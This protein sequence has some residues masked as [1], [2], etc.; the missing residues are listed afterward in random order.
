MKRLSRMFFAA[1]LSSFLLTVYAEHA[2]T[3]ASPIRVFV[4]K[5][6]YTMDKGWPEA[7]AVAVRDGKILS[8]G[9]LESLKPWLKTGPYTI[10][11]RFKDKIIFPGFIEP[12]THVLLGGT[13][14]SA[15][16]ISYLPVAN[17]YGPPFPGLK[18]WPEIVKQLKVYIKA[19]KTPDETVYAWGY[20][21][22][23]MHNK[24]PSK[25]DLDKISK[26][27]PLIFSDCSE[28]LAF[29]NSAAMK[30]YN[31]TQK[32]TSIVGVKVGAD[33]EPN[34]QFFGVAAATRILEEEF[35][36][37]FSQEKGMKSMKYMMDLSRKSGLT[38]TSELNMGTVDLLLEKD[39][40]NRAF[41]NRESP[42]RLVIVTNADALVARYGD[43]APDA[44]K[45]QMKQSN[46]KVMY[47]GVKW[48]ADDAFLSLSMVMENPGYTDGHKG[49][50]NTT[51]DVMFKQMMPW[52][53]AGLQINV[54]NNGNGGN[55]ATLEVL[56]K[57]MSV[58]PRTDHRFTFQHFGMATPEIIRRVAR[59]G[60]IVSINPYYLYTRSEFNAPFVGDERAFLAARLKSVV[61]A[62]IPVS[63]HT[64]TPVAP[65]NPLEE[66]WIAVNRLGLSGK[67]RGPA[68]RVSLDQALRMITIDAAFTL[69][70]EDKIGSI[71]P[72]KFADFTVLE[73][74]PYEVDKLQIR[75][76]PVWG[77]VVGGRVLPSSE[78]KP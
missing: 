67:V 7:S 40:L 63:L 16:L 62:K 71:E 43:K 10:D 59:Q 50:W 48:F 19:A 42:M 49:V 35:K 37:L 34:G 78:I 47:R 29:A 30:K 14:I 72:G 8:V 57:L 33:G 64:D 55:L 2:V 22:I 56:E 17:P 11:R 73:Q 74:D 65:P 54:H 58:Y 41:N 27:Q 4:A 45:T 69:N 39:M 38:T 70:V 36:T 46:D 24:Y 76:I 21:G 75:D 26:T 1:L 52:W 18:T 3:K 9:T 23:A 31:I 53:K 13:M 77:T 68:E 60:G 61:D 32:D 5:K 12:H 44:L 15:P 6:I 66:V 51:R 20:D 28:H 25:D